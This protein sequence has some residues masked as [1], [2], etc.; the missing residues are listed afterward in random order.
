MIHDIPL[1]KLG[2]LN[3]EYGKNYNSTLSVNN[4]NLIALHISYTDFTNSGWN[5]G[6]G[7]VRIANLVG[8][9]DCPSQDQL[10]LVPE[11]M[12]VIVWSLLGLCVSGGI[13]WRK[14]KA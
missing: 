10:V 12:S 14:R 5:Y 13:Y 7:N 8:T 4:G 11:P 9:N 2:R 3:S 6:I 1:N